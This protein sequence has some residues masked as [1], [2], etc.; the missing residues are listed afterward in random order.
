MSR[1]ENGGCKFYAILPPIRF[2]SE[3]PCECE[4]SFEAQRFTVTGNINLFAFYK[5]P[6]VF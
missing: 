2:F 4:S 5:K 6:R 1:G 3:L